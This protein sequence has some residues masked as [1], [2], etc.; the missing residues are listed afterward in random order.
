MEDICVHHHSF[1]LLH[2]VC[3]DLCTKIHCSFPPAASQGQDGGLSSRCSRELLAPLVEPQPLVPVP[4]PTA[5]APGAALC[6]A[7]P[8][9]PAPAAAD[10][11]AAEPGP[12]QPPA[13]APHP[14]RS[15]PLRKRRPAGFSSQL[16]ALGSHADAAVAG[17]DQGGA[18]GQLALGDTENTRGFA[19]RCDISGGG[20]I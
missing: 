2:L 5:A 7:Q 20:G 15:H 12:S 16:L 6:A 18:A 8:P 11:P 17:G 4:A 9:A 13:A 1:M 10:P 19:K 14:A 3:F